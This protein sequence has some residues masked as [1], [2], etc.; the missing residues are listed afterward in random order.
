[1]QIPDRRNVGH[2]LEKDRK[3]TNK[4]FSGKYKQVSLLKMK[5]SA[6]QEEKQQVKY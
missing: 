3:L 2:S 1:M 4:R 5:C 6:T